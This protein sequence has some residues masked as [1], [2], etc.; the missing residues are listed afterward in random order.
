MLAPTVAGADPRQGH[1]LCPRA[2]WHLSSRRILAPVRSEAQRCPARHRQPPAGLGQVWAPG[3]ELTVM[4]EPQDSIFGL[5]ANGL[6]KIIRPAGKTIIE[7]VAAISVKNL[8]FA[9]LVGRSQ[10]N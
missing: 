6:D 10:A 9:F 1:R 7:F 3:T 4:L 2:L 5:V 8:L